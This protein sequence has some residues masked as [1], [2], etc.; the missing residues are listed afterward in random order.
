MKRL[1]AI[2]VIT[3][4]CA[5]F[6]AAQTPPPTPKPGPEIKKLG[7]FAGAWTSSGDMKP[8]PYGP[9]GK[10]SGTDHMTWMEGGF[11]LLSHSTENTPMGKGTGMA[12]FG[13]DSNE[14]VYTYQAYNSMVEAEHAKGTVNGDTWTWTN[15]Q[16][17]QGKLMRGRYTVTVTSPAAYTFKFEMASEGGDY[18]TVMEGK[19]TKAPKTTTKKK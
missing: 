14:K 11:F 9:G 16:K 12:I 19:A 6:V 5:A 10:F 2:L 13:Y 18:A 17:M 3:I 1:A 15:E 8:S 4:F 7:Y